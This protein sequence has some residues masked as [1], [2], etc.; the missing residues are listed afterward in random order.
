M[1]NAS[2]RPHRG[3]FLRKV[4]QNSVVYNKSL[5]INL[6]NTVN[7]NRTKPIYETPLVRVEAV[8][9]ECGFA[10]SGET[11]NDYGLQD[12]TGADVN[13]QSDSWN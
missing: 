7:M 3:S 13:D 8:S 10:T 1:R 4:Q 6:I 5:E 2:D 11:H 12:F 9:T